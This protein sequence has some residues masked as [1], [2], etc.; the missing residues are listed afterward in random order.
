MYA[1]AALQALNGLCGTF[2]APGGP[3]L[4]FK[5]KLKPAWGEGQEKPPKGDAPKLDKLTM[6]AG[7]A[8]AYLL[9][10]VEAGKLQ[11]MVSYFGDP[12]LSWGNQEATTKA[13]E[14]MKF[15][16]AIDAFM[17]NTALLCDVVLPDATW[18]EQSQV[19]P[20]WLYE[21]F[22]G[23][24][25]EVVKPQYNS[26]PM[27]WITIELAKR[28]GLGH[29][30]PWQNIE[31]AFENQLRGLPFSLEDLKE[32]GFIITDKAEYYKYKKWGS[33]NPP[34]GY[35]SSGTTKTGKYN[36]VNPVAEEK[37]IDPLPDHHEGPTDL[38]TDATYPFHFGNFRIFTHEHSST[39]NNYRLMKNVGTNP[40]WINKMDAHD[41]GI[42]E[43][44]RIRLKSPWGEVEM[45]AHPTWD[46]M[47]GIL[48]SGGGFGHVRGLEGDPKY[49]QFG[50]NN[51]PGIMK[52]NTAE[53]AGGT[54]PFKYI[55]CRLE[56][57]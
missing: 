37:G 9:Q 38:R 20:D 31:E 12:V 3:S 42:K 11:G 41:L 18:L 27:Y 13:I 44:D 15:K 36:F 23:Y 10:D 54:P 24:Y 33:L 50:G 14:K 52:P 19:K 34:E 17:C 28:L 47:P 57:I 48:G 2:D 30:F 16:V 45:T 7:W 22:V 6:W 25:A 29:H 21:A 26:R 8:P 53:E 55:K 46:I 56:K 1:T 32:K 5:R 4:P 49:P 43:K 39:F 51:P 35:G 40:L